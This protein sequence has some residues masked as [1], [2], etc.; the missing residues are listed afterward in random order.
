VSKQKC[1]ETKV[2][3]TVD[4]IDDD[5]P[6]DTGKTLKIPVSFGE[7]A[8]GNLYVVRFGDSLFGPNINQGSIYRIVTD[9]CT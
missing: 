9:R 5:L 1:H 6:I 4:R 3:E 2:H 7:D 8:V